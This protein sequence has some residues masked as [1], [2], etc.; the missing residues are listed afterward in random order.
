MKHI[1]KNVS[2]CN[3]VCAGLMLI[4]LVLQFMPFW[5][6]PDK[7]VSIQS[8]IWQPDT[9]KEVTDYLRLKLGADYKIDQ[10]IAMPI[11]SIILCVAGIICSLIKPKSFF[12]ALIPAFCGVI[13]IWGYLTKPA[14]QLGTG[15]VLHLIICIIMLAIACI[16]FFSHIKEV[17]DMIL[18]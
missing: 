1:K 17:K 5:E 4:L 3:Y 18:S 7:T 13:G 8:Y 14:F 15:W 2:I 11:W 6:V 10:I 12:T 9:N 16:T